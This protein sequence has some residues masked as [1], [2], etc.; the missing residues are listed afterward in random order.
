MQREDMTPDEKRQVRALA[1]ALGHVYG[2][3]G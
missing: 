1:A 2:R 3:K